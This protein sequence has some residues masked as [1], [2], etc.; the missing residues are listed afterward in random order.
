GN[1]VFAFDILK[2]AVAA[3]WFK[4]YSLVFKGSLFQ[5]NDLTPVNPDMVLWIGLAGVVAAVFGHSFS[6]FTQFKGGKGVATAA[7]G[8]VVLIPVAC[9]AGAVLWVLTYYSTRYVSLAS[10]MAAT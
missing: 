3:G 4:L 9:L 10:I 8:L 5:A 6:V 2:G 7:G 1:T